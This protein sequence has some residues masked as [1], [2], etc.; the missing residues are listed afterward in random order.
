MNSRLS[1]G[2][3]SPEPQ[4]QSGALGVGGGCLASR[5]GDEYE[6]RLSEW[7]ARMGFREPHDVEDEQDQ[8]LMARDK[9]LEGED[10][11]VLCGEGPQPICDLVLITRRMDPYIQDEPDPDEDEELTEPSHRVRACPTCYKAKYED[12]DSE[13]DNI[14]HEPHREDGRE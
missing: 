4:A 1:S 13:P 8:A 3:A 2:E 5:A 6:A 7:K 12:E 10:Y 9:K 14:V 11:C